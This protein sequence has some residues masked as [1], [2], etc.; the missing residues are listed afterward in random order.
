MG[1]LVDSILG[2]TFQVNLLKDEIRLLKQVVDEQPKE[3][4][5]KMLE[6]EN[7]LLLKQLRELQD[8]IGSYTSTA[9]LFVNDFEKY[10]KPELKK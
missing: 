4:R 2:L 1:K 9:Y 10:R 7:E 5:I 8:K 3:A 6:I